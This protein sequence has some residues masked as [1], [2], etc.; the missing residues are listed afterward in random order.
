MQTTRSFIAIPLSP[1]VARAAIRLIDR[2]K[3]SGDGIKWVPTDNFHLTLKFLG[4]VETIE[5]PKVC[6]VIRSVLEEFE[7][8]D[9]HVAGTGALPSIEKARVLY[10]GIDDPSGSLK[11]IA[12]TLDLE[13]AELGFKREPRDYVPHLALGRTRGGSRRASEEVVT[14]VKQFADTGLGTMAVDEVQLI[15]SFLD[16]RGPTYHVLDSIDL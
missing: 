14:R 4:E 2:L 6:D 7:S 16:K 15:G 10:A 1:E 9:I 5:V 3:E 8:F 13:L 12:E 11:T